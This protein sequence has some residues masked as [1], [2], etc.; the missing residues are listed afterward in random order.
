[1]RSEGVEA[2]KARY[3][4]EYATWRGMVQRCHYEKAVSYPHYGAKG[5]TVCDRWRFFAN[6]Y[7]DMGPRPEGTHLDRT[8]SKQGYSKENCTW[9]PAKERG[10][11]KRHLITHDG[12]TLSITDWADRVGLKNTTLRSRLNVYGWSVSKALST[13]AGQ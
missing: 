8:D 1:M 13:G 4:Q 9:A 11:E 7:E 12:E 2:L 5:I 10:K 3:H 6:F